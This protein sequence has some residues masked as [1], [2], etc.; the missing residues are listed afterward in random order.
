MQQRKVWDITH[1][2][3]SASYIRYGPLAQ[4]GGRPWVWF[5]SFSYHRECHNY[6]TSLTYTP[7]NCIAY[8]TSFRELCLLDPGS[9]F[10]AGNP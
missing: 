5:A 6:E 4:N 8:M 1:G 2:L 7:E 3:Q 10:I 9:L